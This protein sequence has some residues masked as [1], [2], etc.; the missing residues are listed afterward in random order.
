VALSIFQR[1][2]DFVRF[3]QSGHK[4]TFPSKV[5]DGDFYR[6]LDRRIADIPN[7]VPGA[8]I[9]ERAEERLAPRKNSGIYYDTP[10]LRLLQADVVLRTTSNPKT[11]AYCACKFGENAERI[12]RDHRYVFSGED[13]RTIQNDPGGA[14][15]VAT[16]KRLMAR[17]DIPHP[18]SVLQAETGIDPLTLNPVLSLIQLRRTFYVLLD[19]EDALRCSLD[20][21]EVRLLASFVAT[22]ASAEFSEVEV[23]VYPRIKEEVL[24]DGRVPELMSFLISSLGSAFGCTEVHDSKYRRAMRLLGLFPIPPD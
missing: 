16:V 17:R 20:R 13:K 18:G 14:A 5:S 24:R 23:P 9:V 6:W 21:A 4:L 12:R 2:G 19:G 22:T 10:D 3:A 15:A 7:A 8:S 11:H 1:E